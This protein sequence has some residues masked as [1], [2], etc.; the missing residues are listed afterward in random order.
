[1]KESREPISYDL[2][3]WHKICFDIIY[4]QMGGP[5]RWLGKNR[6]GPAPALPPTG[7]DRVGLQAEATAQPRPGGRFWAGPARKARPQIK[8]RAGP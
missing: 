2:V 7:P 6:A 4:V 8:D 3:E 5:A 1:M